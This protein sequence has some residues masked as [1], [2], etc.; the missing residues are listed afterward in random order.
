MKMDALAHASIGQLSLISLR[1]E[2]CRVKAAHR[3]VMPPVPVERFVYITRGSVCFFME[4]G[5][6]CAGERDMVYLPKNTAYHSQWL[7]D[8]SFVV[9]DMLLRSGDGQDIRFGDTPGV[10]FHDAHHVYDGL[11]AELAEKADADGPFD[12][13]ERISLSFKLL[14]E[15]ARDTNRTELDE[16]YSRIKQAV[17]YLE[18]NY[19]E[20]FSVETLAKLCSLSTTSFRRFFVECKGLSPVEYRNRLRIQ[21]AS[22]LLKTGRYTVGEVAEQVGI[23]DIKYFGKLF[24]HHTGLTPSM[25]KKN[26]L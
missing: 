6:L 14:C 3:Y 18:S 19:T 7:E 11:L 22:E 8:A 12:W 20:D 5:K 26:G 4:K 2:S 15:M 24:K 10:L 9:V 21:K 13:L 17:T 1:L 23:R 25:L 16:K